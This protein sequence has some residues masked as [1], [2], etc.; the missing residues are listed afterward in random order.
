MKKYKTLTKYVPP[1]NQLKVR[2]RRW[3]KFE[4]VNQGEAKYSIQG[5][6][7]S[8]FKLTFLWGKKFKRLI[9]IPYAYPEVP[10]PVPVPVP[11]FLKSAPAPAPKSPVY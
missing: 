7:H 8:E 10:V 1:R 3:V 6:T 9:T 4:T 11:V 2:F 5:D